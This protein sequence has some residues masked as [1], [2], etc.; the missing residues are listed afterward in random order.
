MTGF[1]HHDKGSVSITYGKV[2]VDLDT[3]AIVEVDDGFCKLLGYAREDFN[4]HRSDCLEEKSFCDDMDVAPLSDATV[5][6]SHSLKRIEK[7]T[8]IVHGEDAKGLSVKIQEELVKDDIIVLEHR[9]IKRN[10]DIAF[11]FCNA[12]VLPQDNGRNILHF[13][14]TDMTSSNEIKHSIIMELSEEIPFEY[15]VK[16]D[17][18]HF[19]ENYK[20]ITGREVV[21]P[22]FSKELAGRSKMSCES[23][24]RLQK[25][26]QHFRDR[27]LKH[28]IQI[29]MLVANGT[30]EWFEAS[31]KYSYDVKT[32]SAK[33]I[34]ILK[35]IESQKQDSELFMQH[36]E[37]GSVQSIFNRSMTEEKVTAL[38]QNVDAAVLGALFLVDF[39]EMELFR[40]SFGLLADEAVLNA[41]VEELFLNIQP[42]DVIGHLGNDKFLI[43]IHNIREVK[44][45]KEFADKI[46]D[47]VANVC[48]NLNLEQALTVSIGI[49]LA[50]GQRI[51][52]GL[53]SEA[54]CALYRAKNTGKD[55]WV[56][57]E[58]GM[59]VEKYIRNSNR[60]RHQ[61]NY[62]SPVAMGKIWSDLVDKLYQTPNIQKGIQN[63]IEFLGK[64]FRLD[65]VFIFENDLEQKTT[66][67][68]LQWVRDGI[69]NTRESLQNVSIKDYRWDFLYNED[70]IFY[71]S[72]TKKL[73][74]PVRDYYKKEKLT[75]F[76]QAKIMDAGVNV[77][78][79]TFAICGSTRIWV[80][81]EI[82]M[83]ILMSRLLG[84]T[85]RKKRID[86]I[87][88]LYY[89]NTR[90]IL[91]GVSSGIYVI[92]QNTRELLYF[93]HAIKDMLKNVGKGEKCFEALFGLEH[94]CDNCIM[95]QL[96]EQSSVSA[97]FENEAFGGLMEIT[98]SRMLWENN[99]PAYIFTVNRRMSTPEE[100][101]Q[102][103]KQELLEKRYAF[104][105]SHSCDYIC[106]IDVDSD[107]FQLTI[108]NDKIYCPFE[109][110][111]GTFSS[112]VKGALAYLVHKESYETIKNSLSLDNFR[113]MD[114]EGERFF[115]EE[116]RIMDPDGMLHCKEMS[117]FLLNDEDK[118]SVVATFRDITERKKKEIMDLMERQRL[119]SAISNIYPFVISVNLTKDTYTMLKYNYNENIEKTP[120]EGVFSTDMEKMDYI[121]HPDD[122]ELFIKNFSIEHVLQE[123]E[124]GNTDL[125][126]EI[127]MRGLDG[128]Y[129][130][131]SNLT[132]KIDN[133]IND[134]ILQITFSRYID[135]QKKMEQDLKDALYTAEKANQAKSDFLSRMSHEI[136]TPM[137]AIIGM[138]E[139]AKTVLEKPEY[140]KNCLEK[141]DV[142]ARYL[143]SLINDILDMSRI[144]SNRINISRDV[145]VMEDLISNIQ[146]IIAPQ[147]KEKGIYFEVIEEGLSEVYYIGD[148][149]RLNQILINLLSNALKFTEKGGDICLK[150]KENRKEDKEVYMCFLVSDNGVGMSEEFMQVMYRPFE[151]ENIKGEQGMIGTGLGL[152]ITKNI[153]SMMGG[154]IQVES[155]KSRGTQFKV[156]IKLGVPEETHKIH[157][158]EKKYNFAEEDIKSF[159]GKH[160]LVVEDNELNQEIVLTL[161]EM[162]EFIVDCAS[163]G[164][165]A[166]Q[167]FIQMGTYYYDLILMD[168]RMP[169]KNGLESTKEIR[170][171]EGDYAKNIPIIAMTAN[172]FSED[173]AKSFAYGMSDHL[174]KPIEIEKF[175]QILKRYLNK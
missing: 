103:R 116:Y 136:R 124:K 163:N 141:T 95:K 110:G 93:N 109:K 82:D 78:T 173:I 118:L 48:K 117:V 14:C 30:Y 24:D 94:P 76:L 134:D 144:E 142:S 67:N 79:I 164:E 12:H 20:N 111:E 10:G 108:V 47:I 115:V 50:E 11:L 128:Q 71:C 16:T 175:Y 80:Q 62:I 26:Y 88:D 99:K 27:G 61:N 85:I 160:V 154:H 69:T 159:R 98:A 63:A 169:V 150:I 46:Q 129:H 100:L 44:M 22:D 21:I 34:G 143:L 52:H 81:D 127:R 31:F 43:Y 54:E 122:R 38:L 15:E 65:K 139:I 106:D 13:F 167:R 25:L 112:F 157:M 35:N 75:A 72:D 171:L 123:F 149:L 87:L 4:L 132:T 7:Y 158:E 104:I 84:E 153:V 133:P 137:N 37:N 66:C 90:N 36:A 120:K 64:V 40:S 174:L 148:K 56:L 45:A 156:E 155:E 33:V 114:R 39:D 8:D 6:K 2:K 59:E 131:A 162:K 97:V 68:T 55:C 5:C 51:Y 18:I 125:Y 60:K 170:A 9:A 58:T 151:Q 152:S 135:E 73:S 145:F 29:Q 101:E 166:V 23:I 28:T 92:D 172:A 83:L 147:A 53:F 107:Q 138:T 19:A 140:L 146:S 77:G 96:E 105:Y 86:E 113:R 130:W 119:Y 17:T 57:F 70:G 49:S 91:N 165:E 168:I 74:K 1:L 121:I 41:F 32:Q 3:L 126:T 161:L 102:K 89:E 42:E